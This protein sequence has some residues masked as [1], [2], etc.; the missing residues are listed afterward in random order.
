MGRH[1]NRHKK[2]E[3]FY[4]NELELDKNKFVIIQENDNQYAIYNFTGDCKIMVY[5]TSNKDGDKAL[6][7]ITQILNQLQ[8]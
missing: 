7:L 8:E 6:R 1:R 3:I 5:R 4:V 2:V